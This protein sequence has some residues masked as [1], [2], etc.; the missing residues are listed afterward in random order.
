MGG[1]CRVYW[2][3]RDLPAGM[4]RATHFL[5]IVVCPEAQSTIADGRWRGSDDGSDVFWV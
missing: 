3:P 5:F 2:S 1:S 4:R